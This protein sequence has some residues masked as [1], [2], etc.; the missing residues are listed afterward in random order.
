MA[1]SVATALPTDSIKAPPISAS[2]ESSQ[3]ETQHPR[4]VFKTGGASVG[5]P[6]GAAVGKSVGD[7]LGLLEG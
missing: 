2:S 4:A 5:A 3:L 6:D 7:S 1:V